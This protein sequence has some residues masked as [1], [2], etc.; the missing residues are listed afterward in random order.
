MGGGASIDKAT[1]LALKDEY[2]QQKT[3]GVTDEQLFYKLK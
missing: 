1:Y 2:E 3:Q